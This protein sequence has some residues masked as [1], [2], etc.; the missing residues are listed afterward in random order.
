MYNLANEKFII[1]V[2][3]RLDE[4]LIWFSRLNIIFITIYFLEVSR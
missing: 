3:H 2:Y 4:F 1:K